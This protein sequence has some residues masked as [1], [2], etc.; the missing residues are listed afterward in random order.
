MN[1]ADANRI[2]ETV[3]REQL[4]AMFAR[5]RA[6]ITDWTKASP[7]NPAVTLGWTWNLMW[8]VFKNSERLRLPIIRSM[9][10]AF[11]DYLDDDLKP[12]KKPRRQLPVPAHQDPVFD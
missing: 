6:E 3:T 8:P 10:R 7:N 4:A 12:P 11:G 9:V 1:R 2:A 5:A